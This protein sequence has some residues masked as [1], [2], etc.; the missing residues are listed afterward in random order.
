MVRDPIKFGAIEYFSNIARKTGYQ[1]NNDGDIQ[2]FSEQMLLSLRKSTKS[3]TMLYGKRTEAMFAYVAGGL[4]KCRMIKCEDSGD[5]FVAGLSVQAPDYRLILEDGTKILVE[6][7]NFR[8][9]NMSPFLL[10][11]EYHEKLERYAK[12]NEIELKIAVYFSDFKKWCLLSTKSFKK[13]K[14]GMEISIAAAFAKNEMSILGDVYVSTLPSL[15]L[16]MMTSP[17]EANMLNDDGQAAIT[18]R[19]SKIFC[20]NVELHSDIDQ[21]IA[22]YFM[23]F[24]NWPQRAEAVVIGGRLHGVIFTCSTDETFED[25]PFSAIGDLSS[26][27]SWAFAEHTIQDGQVTAL[28]VI[29]DPDAFS[30]KIPKEHKSK[31]LPLWQFIVM[32]NYDFD[33]KL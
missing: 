10:A 32:P 31:E 17:E 25:Q 19:S 5:I 1:L 26:M 3:M 21:R 20:A 30:P 12:L 6:V 13:V 33:E 28:D 24:G 23:R 2:K 29:Y 8:S 18:F 7:K 14:K 4:G 16:E 27:I 11:S 22:F 9:K 15:R